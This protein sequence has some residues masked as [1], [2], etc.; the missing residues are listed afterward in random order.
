MLWVPM[1]LPMLGKLRLPGHNR[2]DARPGLVIVSVGHHFPEA[3]DA[4]APFPIQASPGFGAHR[5]LLQPAAAW[6]QFP[7]NLTLTCRNPVSR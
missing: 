7:L 5:K 2:Q 4:D 6:S 3:K 1:M